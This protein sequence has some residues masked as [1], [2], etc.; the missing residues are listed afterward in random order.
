ML[1][2]RHAEQVEHGIRD[3]GGQRIDQ[4][5]QTEFPDV[6]RGSARTL[7]AIKFGKFQLRDADRI[8]VAHPHR[9]QPGDIAEQRRV[10]V[11]PSDEAAQPIDIELGVAR[12]LIVDQEMDCVAD[13]AG[14]LFGQTIGEE[15]RRAVVFADDVGEQI[16]QR[17]QEACHRSSGA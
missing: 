11:L 10:E 13:D 9:H 6:G 12:A 8:L 7:A 15:R 1:P 5:I 2:A 16:T 3:G 14:R 17:G 4:L